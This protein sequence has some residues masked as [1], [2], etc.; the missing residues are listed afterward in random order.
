MPRKEDISTKQASGGWLSASPLLQQ[1]VFH[2]SG[3]EIME[4]LQ[5][6]RHGMP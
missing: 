1:R 3:S 2:V 5:A 4:G 6:L